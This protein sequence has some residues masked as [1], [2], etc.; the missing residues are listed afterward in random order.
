MILLLIDIIVFLQMALLGVGD[1]LLSESFTRTTSLQ[2]LSHLYIP[3][4]VLLT[5]FVIGF[6]YW[7][8]DGVNTGLYST[9][10]R[11]MHVINVV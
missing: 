4:S 9:I 8:R 7:W 10:Y 1:T 2:A 11:T 3:F 5:L 6:L